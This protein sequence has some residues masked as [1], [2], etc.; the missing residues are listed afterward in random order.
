M[1]ARAAAVQ[2]GLNLEYFTVAWNALEA[3]VALASGAVAGSIALIGFGLDSVIEVSSGGILLWRLHS[4][5]DEPRREGLERRAQ[6]LV[7]VTLLAL[8]AYVA[9]DSGLSLVRKEA[10]E[11]S[12]PGIVLAI[13]SLIVM[14]LLARSKRK[15]ASVLASSAMQADSR[16]TDICAYLSA[17][18]LLGLLL[19][20]ALGWWW[21]DPVAG[22]A[23]TPLIAYEGVQAVR[24]KTCC[25]TC[26]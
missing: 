5:G 24:G 1:S 19:N 7:G 14:P 18:L 13:V 17:I 21:A 10:P 12:L 16:Q 23:M 6:R 2:R 9:S 26:G 22:I 15:V 20:A 4:D 3:M 8:A 11:R 25:D